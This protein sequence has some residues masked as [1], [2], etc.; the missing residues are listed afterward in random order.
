[1][2]TLKFA[3]TMG[4][5]AGSMTEG[6]SFHSA[7]VD[8]MTP[9]NGTNQT[10]LNPT[11]EATTGSV[12]LTVFGVGLGTVD[13]TEHLRRA[14]TNCEVTDW[15]SETHV[16]CRSVRGVFSSLHVVATVGNRVTSTSEALSFDRPDLM[17]S[18][19]SVFSLNASSNVPATG[20]IVLRL[21]GSALGTQTVSPRVR[22]HETAAEASDW[23]SD[24]STL[25]RSVSGMLGSFLTAI[26]SGILT[27]SIT[28]GLS[29]DDAGLTS[30]S[31]MNMH[32]LTSLDIIL[33]ATDV[34]I[35]NYS[36][37]SRFSD[38][39]AESTAW[40]SVSSLVL[41]SSIG[42]LA[43]RW[44][45]V[46]AGRSP[47]TLTDAVSFDEPIV[48]FV[49][50][51]SSHPNASYGNTGRTGSI[52]ISLRGTGFGP[53]FLTESARQDGT[54]SESSTWIS[55][56]ALHCRN[57]RGLGR[58]LKY[59]VTAGHASSTLTEAASFDG[60]ESQFLERI[61]VPTTGSLSFTVFGMGYF[62]HA[63]TA[64]A[65]M[66][67]TVCEA[68]GWFSDTSIPSLFASGSK[69][70]QPMTLSLALAGGSSTF[71]WSYDEISLSSIVVV[72]VNTQASVAIT[73]I[74]SQFSHSDYSITTDIGF[75]TSESSVWYS[76]TSISCNLVKGSGFTKKVIATAGSR[77]GS[78]T[79]I[80][81]YDGPSISSQVEVHVPTT[82]SSLLTMTGQDFGNNHY[83]VGTR[84]GGSASE[85]TMWISDTSV[86]A[87]LPSGVATAHG[88]IISVSTRLNTLTQTWTYFAPNLTAI[89]PANG[90]ILG[91][92]DITFYGKNFGQN[93]YDATASIGGTPCPQ[94]NFTSDTSIVCIGPVGVGILHAAA[95]TVK[96]Q[97]DELPAGVQM[98]CYD[99][100]VTEMVIPDF[101]PTTGG[102]NIS[103]VGA[104]FDL[105]PRP[106]DAHFGSDNDYVGKTAATATYVS[107]TAVR[108]VLPPG[109]GISHRVA[110]TILGYEREVTNRFS[111]L[112][113]RITSL[114]NSSVNAPTLS[115][116]QI[117]TIIGDNFGTTNPLSATARFGGTACESSLWDSDTS[118]RC[119]TVS[120]VSVPDMIVSVALQVG[121]SSQ[122][123]N[124][125]FF[126][127]DQPAISSISPSNSSHTNAPIL[128]SGADG[129]ILY[130]QGI[131]SAGQVYG[132]GFVRIDYSSQIRYS[133][134]ACEY[135]S[136]A[137]DS[138]MSCLAA[139][140]YGR[141]L[142]VIVSVAYQQV[143]TST[144][145]LSFSAPV[146]RTLHMNCKESGVITEAKLQAN[147]VDVTVAQDAS[148]S[149]GTAVAA[150]ATE[151]VL[152]TGGD[153]SGSIGATAIDL[154]AG[155]Y[156]RVALDTSDYEYAKVVSVDDAN[157][158]ITVGRA[159]YPFGLNDNGL[160]V[161]CL[162]GTLTDSALVAGKDIYKI[163]FSSVRSQTNGGTFGSS[164]VTVLGL[165]F[166]QWDLSIG[167]R[168]GMLAT[169]MTAW[170]SDSAIFFKSPAGIVY[171][172]RGNQL[173]AVTV[174]SQVG[175]ITAVYTYDLHKLS[176]IASTNQPAKSI[177]ETVTVHGINF[178][179]FVSCPVAR[180]GFT[181]TQST[182]WSSDSSIY[183]NQVSGAG[184]D[185]GAIVTVLGM[186]VDTVTIVFT[187][188]APHVTASTL[189]NGL[190]VSDYYTTITG[191][192]F[193]QATYSPSTRFAGTNCEQTLW[194]SDTALH[195]FIP[196]GVLTI[197]SIEMTLQTVGPGGS[198]SNTFTYNG[199]L[200]VDL[201]R[202]NVPTTGS[203]TTVLSGE[204]FATS[205]FSPPSRI[206]G[207]ATE[208]TQWI[209]DTNLI[210]RIPSGSY[211]E[212]SSVVTLAN[213]L[214]TLTNMVTYDDFLLSM[215]SPGN[216]PTSGAHIS[217]FG[218][219]FGHSS[220]SPTGRLG[221]T[222]CE[223]TRWTSDTSVLCGISSTALPGVMG[224]AV[225]T[226]Q[227]NATG[228]MHIHSITAIFSFDKPVVTAMTFANTIRSGQMLATVLGYN[229][230]GFEMSGSVREGNT[231]CM[232]THWL[233]DSGLICQTPSGSGLGLPITLT[234]TNLI[235]TVTDVFSYDD[236]SVTGALPNNG[237]VTGLY[238]TQ[239]LGA[240]YGLFNPEPA[241]R[242]AGSACSVSDWASDSVLL[243]QVAPG[244]GVELNIAVTL[245]G[246]FSTKFNVYTY[247]A[248]T[249]SS[250]QSSNSPARIPIG[251]NS[252]LKLF[253]ANFGVYLPS[254]LSSKHGYTISPRTDWT[255]TTSVSVKPPSGT[256]NAQDIIIV[257]HS[258]ISTLSQVATYDRP[259]MSGMVSTNG[260]GTGTSSVTMSGVNFA[261]YDSSIP[262]RVGGSGMEA[263]FWVS[264]S[265]VM[266]QTSAGG[267]YLT[268][269]VATTVAAQVATLSASF[270]FDGPAIDEI[271]DAFTGCTVCNVFTVLGHGFGHLSNSP[272]A[273]L[274][275]D[276]GACEA[277]VWIS[278][279]SATC[280]IA[281]FS[282]R[283][284]SNDQGPAYERGNYDTSGVKIT[285]YNQQGQLSETITYSTVGLNQ[286][287]QMNTAPASTRN[288]TMTGTRFGSAL[289]FITA[290]DLG[291]ADFSPKSRLGG[292]ACELSQW[293][294]ET[295][296][297]CKVTTG[298]LEL[299]A[300]SI[301]VALD[302][303]ATITKVF[304]YDSV[305]VDSVVP[306]TGCTQCDTITIHGK[307]LALSDLS[308]Q[309]R[310]G[311]VIGACKA[312]QWVS[313]TSVLCSLAPLVSTFLGGVYEPGVSLTVANRVGTLSSAFDFT[314][315]DMSSLAKAN[316]PGTGALITV[317]G[318]RFGAGL[319][320]VVKLD[321][322]SIDTTLKARIGHSSCEA[323]SWISDSSLLCT[324]ALGYGLTKSS[325]VTVG[326]R[327]ATLTEAMSYSSTEV[328]RATLFEVYQDST[329]SATIAFEDKSDTADIAAGGGVNA[330]TSE[331]TLVL[332]S[333]IPNL[334]VNEYIKSNNDEY[335]KV[336]D[337]ASDNITLTVE[338]N[339]AP[340]GLTQGSIATAVEGSA[341]TLAEG[342]IDASDTTVKLV[343]AL[344][345]L[346]V[347]DYIKS[348]A[349]EY[350]KVTQISGDSLTIVVERNGS[351]FG[352]VHGPA[353][354]AS[355]GT[356]VVLAELNPLV[357]V[358]N[359]PRSAVPAMILKMQGS[360]Y[361]VH[362][363][364]LAARAGSTACENSVWSSDTMLTCRIA[365]GSGQSHKSV[366]TA[367]Y[368]YP[369]SL[370]N[371]L[372]YDVPAALNVESQVN[373]AMHS[374][375]LINASTSATWSRADLSV[376]ARLGG[377][378]TESTTWLSD[379]SIICKG[380]TGIGSSL[381]ILV[382]SGEQG[383]TKTDIMSYDRPDFFALG[384][385]SVT[386]AISV[387]AD[388]SKTVLTIFGSNMGLY[389]ISPKAR[390]GV[391]AAESTVWESTSSMLG[392]V[393][394][395]TL[396]SRKLDLTATMQNG[397]TVT[398]SLSYN[399]PS[400]SSLIPEN[401]AMVDTVVVT[402]AGS[403]FGSMS[404]T[405]QFRVGH[406]AA[407]SSVWISDT[408]VFGMTPTGGPEKYGR[409]FAISS[410]QMLAGSL[411][412]TFTYNNPILSAPAPSNVPYVG[413][414]SMSIIGLGFSISSFSQSNRLGGTSCE[415]TG[416]ISDS[417]VLCKSAAGFHTDVGAAVTAGSVVRLQSMTNSYTY[418]GPALSYVNPAN[419][420]A[421]GRGVITLHGSEGFAE[422]DL[423]V[424]ARIG[425]SS[426]EATA[427]SGEGNYSTITCR[428]PQGVG[429]FQQVVVTVMSQVSTFTES[430][431]FNLPRLNSIHPVNG[432]TSGG[433]NIT[434]SGGG[435]GLEDY[436][437]KVV[438]SGTS[439]ER[440]TYTSDSSITCLVS[441]GIYDQIDLVV[442]VSK[443]TSVGG[444]YDMFT[445]D[446]PLISSVSTFNSATTGGATTSLFGANFGIWS[447]SLRA[448]IAPGDC[449]GT[450]W[451]S[452][453]TVLCKIPR[454]TG[455]PHSISVTLPTADPSLLSDG[456][457][458]GTLS[459]IFSYDVPSITHVTPLNSATAGG[460]TVTI[461][462][463]NFGPT[464]N[465]KISVKILSG[466]S[467]V[468]PA[469]LSCTY[470]T[471]DADCLCI[472][473]YQ[474]T[475][476]TGGSFDTLIVQ[477]AAGV[478]L[479]KPF[480]VTV[481]GQVATTS[482]NLTFSFDA[483]TILLVYP[484]F[485]GVAG[486]DIISVFGTNFGP[487]T[488]IPKIN[489]S[490]FCGPGDGCVEGSNL[491][492]SVG[493]QSPHDILLCQVPTGTGSNLDIVTSIDY[494]LATQANAFSY[495]QP[496]PALT[497]P[498]YAPTTGNTVVTIFGSNF[499]DN[500][501]T[502][503][504]SI[505]DTTCLA[506]VWTSDSLVSCTLAAGIGK[507][508]RLAVDVNAQEGSRANS[509][510]YKAPHV[511][512]IF[513]MGGITAGG[514][515]A[516]IYGSN[517]G[518]AD[519][520]PAASLGD[521]VCGSTEYTSDSSVKCDVPP[522]AGTQYV[523]VTVAG[524]SPGPA[525]D[526]T[527]EFSYDPPRVSS[528]SRVNDATSGGSVMTIFGF[529]FGV[530]D[531][532]PT[533]SVG[534]V[535]QYGVPTT[536]VSDT[537]IITHTP[538]G[539]GKDLSIFVELGRLT[540]TTTKLFSYDKPS[541]TAVSPRFG[542]TSGGYTVTV[543][544]LNFGSPASA[545]IGS[546]SASV[547]AGSIAPQSVRIL[548]PEGTG[549]D[550]GVELIV[551]GQAPQ[552]SI[553]FSYQPPTFTALHPVNGPTSGSFMITVSGSNF[554]SA[555]VAT[556]GLINVSIGSTSSISVTAVIEHQSVKLA[557][558][559]G[560]GR[561]FEAGISVDGQ[562]SARIPFIFSYDRPTVTHVSPR[563]APT[564]G[565]H[566]IVLQGEN[567]G[568]EGAGRT[569][570]VGDTACLSTTYSSHT[571]A[572]C[573]VPPGIGKNHMVRMSVSAPGG[574]Q[575]SS[576]TSAAPDLRF[577]FGNP[578]VSTIKAGNGPTSGEIVLTL[579]G[580][581]FG[582]FQSSPVASV[583]GTRCLI[584]TWTSDSSVSCSPGAG[585]GVGDDAEVVVSQQ[586]GTVTG[587]FSYDQVLLTDL[588]PRNGPTSSGLRITA[589]G[590]NFGKH[591]STP[592]VSLGA[593]ESSNTEWATH[594]CNG[595]TRTV[596]WISDTS[597]AFIPAY[598]AGTGKDISVSLMGKKSTLTIA[599]SYDKPVI[600][601]LSPNHGPTSGSSA[602]TVHGTNFGTSVN[603]RST[604]LNSVSAS[605]TYQTHQSVVMTT[606]AGTGAGR[607]VSTTVD[608][609]STTFSGFF[610]YDAP[611]VTSI[612]PAIGPATGGGASI[613]LT[614]YGTNFGSVGQTAPEAITVHGQSC[615]SLTLDNVVGV[616]SR[617]S[618]TIPA[619]TKTTSG[620]ACTECNA[621]NVPVTVSV[622]G[623]TGTSIRFAYSNDGSTQALSALWCQALKIAFPSGSGASDSLRWVDPDAD[624]DTSDA[625]Q[626]YCLQ[627][628][629][630]GG[631]S[632]V[633][634]YGTNSYTPTTGTFGLV[635]TTINGDGKLADDMIDLIGGPRAVAL[636]GSVASSTSASVFTL[637][638]ESPPFANT[639]LGYAIMIGTQARIITGYTAARAVTV[640]PAFSSKPNGGTAYSIYGPMKEYRI[641]SAG[642]T[643]DTD[644]MPS[645]RLFLRS[646][647]KYVD[648]SFGQG[649]A[650][651]TSHA[652]ASC[653]AAS[654]AACSEWV[655]LVSPGYV[656]SLAFGFSAGQAGASDDCNRYMTDYDG[657][658]NH[659]FGHFTDSTT[660]ESASSDVRCFVTGSCAEGAVISKGVK[661]T[662][663]TIMVRNYV[664]TDGTWAD[665]D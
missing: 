116:G 240:N 1:M 653:L 260:P 515:P 222:A 344:T 648:T 318:I 171:G 268:L 374:T 133:A 447:S 435:Y 320:F 590:Q 580:A 56:T 238:T 141:T 84:F 51:N 336:T 157:D 183:C 530:V 556:D 439:C 271:G 519:Y 195:A 434:I 29:Y 649:I 143:G 409:L 553:S 522:G 301:S 386:N 199:P 197:G 159:D 161:S 75:S 626:V 274:G 619:N 513:P 618:C 254:S 21:L 489:I 230:A 529:N 297:Q 99:A 485:G 355:A 629:D 656:D 272:S 187:Y 231:A 531:T 506:A 545:N 482:G 269:D 179:T 291:F 323:T 166:N 358:M 110:L 378:T 393:A 96:G 486:V 511:T 74:G 484:N 507:G 479:A 250:A 12:S 621:L 228:R 481:D 381:L 223:S 568:E 639:W 140:G 83:S 335:M 405:N 19:S 39:A 533:A 517:F 60:M 601:A 37:S 267:F 125:S 9:T 182:G 142:S 608:G 270:T 25:C 327:V 550:K 102:I 559:A 103:I 347:N 85:Y 453:S 28:E 395:G 4:T 239:F 370:T 229:F 108:L 634:Q 452:D 35:T 117:A 111:Y 554:G 339:A 328:S 289:S 6:M 516:T 219:T 213:Q 593:T 440:S 66:G 92:I 613:K 286:I 419:S 476:L 567:F 188:N 622:D 43:S 431:T 624:G 432:P 162:P 454:Q 7:E 332:A 251:I 58:T 582:T 310:V 446:Q 505:G 233:S 477:T 389:R 421:S 602:V 131:R 44:F 404:V 121:D 436:L 253:G 430:F 433:Y 411:T 625:T 354:A 306:L 614:V 617:F 279:S 112:A 548:A 423:S 340:P 640:S 655:T 94:M 642:Y 348:A 375:Q 79:E 16:S 356:T 652:I 663:V 566:V 224:P 246:K 147:S 307:N 437:P 526:I 641:L 303:K 126:S 129:V 555:S 598:G 331:T 633:L 665:S 202:R 623:L 417:A 42:T 413:E 172:D 342:G 364:T 564:T 292:S 59:I 264:D 255:S 252:Y 459:D 573:S 61:N 214:T 597:I 494:Q 600:T 300:A 380:V 80:F 34:G 170:I 235:S 415:A 105:T 508:L 122:N 483:P 178:M 215:I 150:G 373:S 311:G 510:S 130:G 265:S 487:S 543:S 643:T 11:N 406:T 528:I 26:T 579:S 97:S 441:P 45:S 198:I 288:V 546:T 139:K 207:S 391:T 247:D 606:P 180:I 173:I 607:Q 249:V 294:S 304:T 463:T 359:G 242:L 220:L 466:Y 424:S 491:C 493:F 664:D 36:P 576:P 457:I 408:S 638:A 299:L 128:P 24:T 259:L 524:Q 40:T 426:C 660:F 90:P 352:L 200:N 571:Q 594:D 278:E 32:H 518:T 33:G 612:I 383:A 532:S 645:L 248:P 500:D 584:T 372:S 287:V 366:V 135:S 64:S 512:S 552:E 89:D 458:Q 164:Q 158:K 284:W 561:S 520:T 262:F 13:R 539:A 610:C 542:P 586:A 314:S 412:N 541:L 184:R 30:S 296:M 68:T 324:T 603:T 266:C 124:H 326:S 442:S 317:S 15:I 196:D 115:Q 628:V 330:L 163:S 67:Q 10:M 467:S 521:F 218:A 55:D 160:G 120:G 285:I 333:A 504:A 258:Q 263:S 397:G 174:D 281:A 502:P 509:F 245:S 208:K 86:E 53:Y 596:C 227:H 544:G 132:S 468:C 349:G 379:S 211:T 273:R 319:N 635:A 498:A 578:T 62:T 343:A 155:D 225:I 647:K 243:C 88:A 93:D 27:G 396:G 371:I 644:E 302:K 503:S 113:P 203:I 599:F 471:S 445:F 293:F 308:I 438:F 257:I 462:G 525:S 657:G 569:I 346:D 14:T 256:G 176:N 237:P 201:S 394:R 298:S 78:V 280:K 478:G 448:R 496:Q 149:G 5:N 368:T 77:V 209:S 570:F 488:A 148:Q 534:L 104:N 398:D 581:N 514:F 153:G 193:G 630:G 403:N 384:G 194:I 537:T 73:V 636:T 351:P 377:T 152:G 181:A 144:D 177:N 350:M 156:I 416:W 360:A 52:S 337:I 470:P 57:V 127:Y 191:I 20:S 107:D 361:S 464:E 402:S 87:Q 109:I 63:Y 321:L 123:N 232:S 587:V 527:L 451:V 95:I 47:A 631:W 401:G 420:A 365:T 277:T 490:T 137:S 49:G 460:I 316:L 82:G 414:V 226:S 22:S 206:G 114:F 588:I 376:Q 658:P 31:V 283:Q 165:N 538:F 604:T 305:V 134:T 169:E 367:G 244:I 591:D 651:G 422:S 205:I 410:G 563:F 499:G 589:L 428:T 312:T 575:D 357:I 190:K 98:F 119:G 70:S 353:Q 425:G 605:L 547:V 557:A 443:L 46:T 427:W 275:G 192:N 611:I 167:G 290:L 217:I 168:V 362:Q 41:K 609:Q 662:Y 325:A 535:S 106:A 388:L 276:A 65:R 138:S 315:A 399:S 492:N 282:Y 118:V 146:L 91:Q 72:N 540:A 295:S 501:Y 637:G 54:G 363:P 236:M 615:A 558:P 2:T 562:A 473:D 495:A 101:G 418:D 186:N 583:G 461:K 8:V 392:M 560:A 341:V 189:S 465:G 574:T 212:K 497:F 627:T 100:P 204:G 620:S 50:T 151:I 592:L 345:G 654:Y 3:I 632:K 385:T 261:Q 241:N 69:Q 216:S 76:D 17:M 387:L 234:I 472:E 444:G 469:P 136:W 81:S 650:T 551:G 429:P 474:A 480:S 595:V 400:L 334:D 565:S 475:I 221:L 572:S 456:A 455:S 329:A 322:G 616:S 536:W 210:V 71:L 175:T 549:V 585:L 185:Y 659:C 18:P 23:T 338:R 390:I 646:A 313:D 407:E 145:I 154:V 449:E 523:L 450:E 309:A 38:S 369:G 48:S 577:S 661:H 382:T